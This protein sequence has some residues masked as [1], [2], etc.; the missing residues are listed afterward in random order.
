MGWLN[1]VLVAISVIMVLGLYLLSVTS[2]GILRLADVVEF[3]IRFAG[4][5]E[6][7]QNI[8]PLTGRSV[9]YLLRSC[10]ERELI[11]L[12]KHQLMPRTLRENGLTVMC[13]VLDFRAVMMTYLTKNLKL[14]RCYLRR[15]VASGG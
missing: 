6:Q 12:N 1:A 10:V 11:F 15:S 5:S 14:Q 9:E 13:T 8:V 4:E 2:V 7:I 3:F